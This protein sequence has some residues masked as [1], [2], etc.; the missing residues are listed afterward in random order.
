M[1]GT[2]AT[3]CTNPDYV[4]IDG[5]L[6]GVQTI[7]LSNVP[8]TLTSPAAFTPTPSGGPTQAQN[9]VLKLTGTLTSN[10][11]IT[12]PLPGYYVIDSSGLAAA[13]IASGFNVTLRAVGSGLIVGV[14]PGNARHVYND[15]T[16]VYHVGLPEIGTYA[17]YANAALP[18]WVTSC[19][20]RPF[21]LCDGSTFNAV[22]YPILNVILGGNTLPDLRGATRYT[23]NGGTSRIT[24]A[25]S[26]LDGNT[27]FAT[28][29][30]QTV[31]LLTGN[32]PPYTPTGNNAANSVSVTAAQ[33]FT[34]SGS[35][36]ALVPPG[37]ANIGPSS[38]TVPAQAWTGN[39]QGGT[40]TPFGSIGTGVV[41]GITM[42]RAG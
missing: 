1:V 28:K 2:W 11:Q 40:S 17:D 32:L 27:I 13:G 26:G 36:Q 22:T 9:A 39:A 33:G 15:G 24:T 30:T 8:V 34:T 5:Y 38:F 35:F 7:S 18:G 31:T 21:L 4:A 14:P 16:N 19:T 25:G 6:G 42:I 12:L 3:L 41:A 23:L 20:V 10:V 37:E 29:F